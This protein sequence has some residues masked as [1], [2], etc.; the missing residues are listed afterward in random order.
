MLLL[1][2]PEKKQ[3]PVPP[4]MPKDANLLQQVKSQEEAAGNL[5]K[6][7]VI[8]AIFSYLFNSVMSMVWSAT[9]ILQVITLYPLV[10][11]TYTQSNISL[12]S[13]INKIV[14][15]DLIPEEI[16]NTVRDFIFTMPS[17]VPFST[18][19][20]ELEFESGYIIV[21]F[22]TQFIILLYFGAIYSTAYFVSQL[23]FSI[24]WKDRMKS[25][26]ER[27]N[28]FYL[29]VFLEVSLELSIISL[30]ELIMRQ[31]DTRIEKFSY[32]V[33]LSAI[34]LY[35]AL[36]VYGYY[37]TTYRIYFINN[38]LYPTFNNRWSILWQ[39]LHVHIDRHPYFYLVFLLRR[40]FLS[41]LLCSIAIY[42]IPPQ[43]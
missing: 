5:N 27:V 3:V 43:A 7:L 22:F 9:N 16:M 32:L 39:D 15:F 37:L 20:H 11:L 2:E 28:A 41:C 18:G 30:I 25:F 23:S 33:S 13:Q 10:Q 17:D 8:N 38:H 40:L 19:F 31:A 12:F 1:E 6:A 14:T 29:K 21:N 36:L 26:Y 42:S 4:Q 34:G 35:L 24:R